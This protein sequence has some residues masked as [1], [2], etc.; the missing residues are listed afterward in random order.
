MSS[1]KKTAIELSIRVISQ[2]VIS[3]DTIALETIALEIIAIE[4]ITIKLPSIV[5]KLSS[6]LSSAET[7]IQS[8]R[9]NQSLL[10]P[11]VS[12]T[13]AIRKITK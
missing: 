2:R 8:T 1:S 7:G 11:V 4:T 13:S 12:K 10:V 6:E 3:Y 9:I 5:T